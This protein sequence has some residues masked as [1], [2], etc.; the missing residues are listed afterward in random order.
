MLA[1]GPL[2]GLGWIDWNARPF[3]P[4]CL[5][6]FAG[7]GF[8]LLWDLLGPFGASLDATLGPFGASLLAP[9]KP[10]LGYR[11]YGAVYMLKPGM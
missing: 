11:T 3:G 10:A 4:R 2:T 9:V 7:S 1:F 5:A 8:I 6:D